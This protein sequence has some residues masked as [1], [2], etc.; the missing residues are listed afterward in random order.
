ML[1]VFLTFFSVLGF[2]LLVWDRVR[3]DRLDAL[4]AA[5]PD[6]GSQETGAR[7]AEPRRGLGRSGPRWLRVGAG[8]AFGA[9]AATKW[10]GALAWVAGMVLAVAWERTRRRR[11]GVPR[12]LWSAVREEWPSLVL[13]FVLAPLIVYVLAWSRWLANHGWSLAALWDNHLAMGDYHRTLSAFEDGEPIHPYLSSA[14]T[15]LLLL[16]PVAYFYRDTG[17]QAAE[18]LGI[19]N[20]VLFWGA[21]PVIPYL[22]I[23]WWRHDEWRAGALLVP[24][25]VQYLPWF[26]VARPMFL[27]YLTP[28]TPFLALGMT[29]AVRDLALAGRPGFRWPVAGAGAIVALSVGVFVFFWPVLVGDPIAMDAWRLRIWFPDW[30]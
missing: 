9:A 3:R 5:E 4:R 7:D 26:A 17:G 1:D 28:V 24:I 11:A 27:F 16:R 13:A 15:W 18:I 6:P 2:A 25:L 22:A 20:P 30:V 14:W 12:P 8:M 10:S 21:I 19:G 23:R 29:A